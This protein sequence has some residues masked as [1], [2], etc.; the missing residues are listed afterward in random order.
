MRDPLEGGIKNKKKMLTPKKFFDDPS[1]ID[2]NT[3]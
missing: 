3:P 2:E 1:I